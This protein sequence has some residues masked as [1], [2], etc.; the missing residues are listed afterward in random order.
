[1]NSTRF[2][3]IVKLKHLDQNENLTNLSNRNDR[4]R[5]CLRYTESLIVM[6]TSNDVLKANNYIIWG[7]ADKVN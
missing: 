2:K 6:P 3:K 5:A 1:M 4:F 7:S